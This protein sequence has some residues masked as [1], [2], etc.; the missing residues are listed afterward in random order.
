MSTRSPFAW[1]AAYYRNI[2]DCL[3]LPY[4]E[5]YLLEE[6]CPDKVQSPCP[7]RRLHPQICFRL[8]NTQRST[9]SVQSVQASSKR[10]HLSSDGHTWLGTGSVS[11]NAHGGN[12]RAI[13][14]GDAQRFR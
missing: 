13:A 6:P 7:V 12:A 1:V 11:E 4:L 10:R 3:D 8:T 9:K 14:V 2:T 5:H